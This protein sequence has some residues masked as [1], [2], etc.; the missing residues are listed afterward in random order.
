MNLL[1]GCKRKIFENMAKINSEVGKRSMA[2][3][4][5]HCKPATE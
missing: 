1:L 5:A 4:I 3:Q 2:Y